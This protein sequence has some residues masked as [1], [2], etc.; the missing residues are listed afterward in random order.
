MLPRP[1]QG[2]PSCSAGP[3]NVAA[4]EGIEERV[5]LCELRLGGGAVLRVQLVEPEQQ[6]SL[7]RPVFQRLTQRVVGYGG[8]AAAADRLEGLHDVDVE[9]E[10]H[11]TL[12]HTISIRRSR[13]EPVG[14]LI[15]VSLAPRLRA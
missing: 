7:M 11:A 5:G 12:V 2:A 6:R 3:A 10:R 8:H 1:A 9:I 14:E 15:R 13:S 4:L